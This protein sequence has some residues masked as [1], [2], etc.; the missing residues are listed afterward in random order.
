MPSRK[1]YIHTYI[2]TVHKLFS[3]KNDNCNPNDT[4]GENEDVF[5]VL[6]TMRSGNIDNIVIG[7]LNVNSFR[8]KHDAMKLMIPGKIDI[9][10]VESKLDDSYP[11]L[12]LLL[13]DMQNPLDVIGTNMG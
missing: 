3:L 13:M 10:I 11:T 7:L 6:N 4:A 8:N 1:T 12:P 5:Q 9:F 2:H